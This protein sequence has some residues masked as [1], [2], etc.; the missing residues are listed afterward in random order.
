MTQNYRRRKTPHQ[1]Q[2]ERRVLTIDIHHFQHRMAEVLAHGDTG[3]SG[4]I[5]GGNWPRSDAPTPIRTWTYEESNHTIDAMEH[6][7]GFGIRGGTPANDEG[8]PH[9]FCFKCKRDLWYS[10]AKAANPS[11][12]QLAG[13]W[14]DP[15]FEILCCSCFRVENNRAI[16]RTWFDEAREIDSS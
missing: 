14:D 16:S 4:L 5:Q 7:L 1:R 12:A 11:N 3:Y 8:H 10:E 6:A 13:M 9:R 2:K 15:L